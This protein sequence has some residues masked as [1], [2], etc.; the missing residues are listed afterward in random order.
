MG[1]VK[2]SSDHSSIYRDK[3]GRFWW[4]VV[5]YVDE[6]GRKRQFRKCFRDRRYQDHQAA[7]EAALAWRKVHSDA[8]QEAALS[9]LPLRLRRVPLSQIG[10]QSD[11]FG[12]VGITVAGRQ[13]PRGINISVTAQ[14]GRSKGFSMHRHGAYGAFRKAVHQRCQWIQVPMPKEEELR[15]RFD[16]WA[17]HNIDFLEQYGVSL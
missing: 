11:G 12:L 13:Q 14:R 2:D 1:I 15:R 17:R 9:A 10:S 8:L 5:S 6:R 7:L 4:C 3:H 16:C